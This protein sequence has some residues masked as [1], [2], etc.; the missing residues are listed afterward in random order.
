M[1]VALA[2]R[3]WQIGMVLMGLGLFFMGL[4]VM[5]FFDRALLAM[6][7]LMFLGSFPLLIGVKKTLNL[8]NP[9]VNGSKWRGIAAFL[10]GVFLVII[11]W[12]FFGIIVE[13]YA[14]ER[15]HC[16]QSVPD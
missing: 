4:G 2:L 7:N 12:P 9:F 11:G 6:G 5:F 1:P 15:V 10:G 8:F 3:A 16:V 14:T 13:G